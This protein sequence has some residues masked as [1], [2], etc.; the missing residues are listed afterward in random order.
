MDYRQY[1]DLSPRITMVA[2]LLNSVMSVIDSRQ[3]EKIA[4]PIRKIV[5]PCSTAIS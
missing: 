4:E 2:V 1:T 3:P 5:A